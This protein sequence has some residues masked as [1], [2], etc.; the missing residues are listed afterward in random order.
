L[1][2]PKALFVTLLAVAALCATI[3][4]ANY[5]LALSEFEKGNYD[6]AAAAFQALV[7]DSPSY[8]FGHYMLGLC[9]LK[10]GESEA[11]AERFRT[12]LEF[13]SDRFEY[14]YGL[15]QALQQSGAYETAIQ[16]LNRAE[17]LAGDDTRLQ[18]HYARGMAH[19]ALNAWEDAIGDL[20]LAAA[21]KPGYKPVMERLAHSYYKAG[22]YRD[23][24]PLLRESI[25]ID[26]DTAANYRLLAESLMANKIDKD[27]AFEAAAAYRAL[28]LG[29][30]AAADLL[31]RAALAA[32]RFDVAIAAFS[33][34]LV[35]SSSHCSARINLAL[36][37]LASERAASAEQA[38]TG[39]QSCETLQS[40]VYATLGLVQRTQG[41]YEEALGN[42]EKAYAILPAS[43]SYQAIEEVRHN[44]EVREFN[45]AAA[46]KQEEDDRRRRELED[47][48]DR[49]NEFIEKE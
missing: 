20:E 18:L 28:R 45:M 49:W 1:I 31:G 2:R 42:Y 26:A 5:E 29:D 32:G 13:N 21:A 38:L 22:R 14:F 6:V 40:N 9:H 33:G 35:D 3:T 11:A 30:S 10:R 25:A 24:I 43:S 47:K 36:A 48:I 39:A 44:I 12:A 23:A 41:R 37:L 27:G 4:E 19:A 8:D 17:A 46:S 15:A 16:T 7:D 34:V